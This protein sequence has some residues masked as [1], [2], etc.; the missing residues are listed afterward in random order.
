MASG[1]K[2]INLADLTQGLRDLEWEKVREM[3]IQLEF[4]NVDL[5]DIEEKTLIDGHARRRS[6]RLG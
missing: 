6:Q 1:E 3:A 5:D 4:K 2:P